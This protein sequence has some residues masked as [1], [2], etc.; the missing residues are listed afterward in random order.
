MSIALVKSYQDLNMIYSL[1]ILLCK[2]FPIFIILQT[3]TRT[4]ELHSSSKTSLALKF[5]FILLSVRH[6]LKLLS[7]CFKMPSQKTVTICPIYSPFLLTIFSL[8]VCVLLPCMVLQF[9]LATLIQRLL[10]DPAVNI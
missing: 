8:T 2:G 4:R 1:C 6:L 3:R 5:N 10:V 9:A 7:I